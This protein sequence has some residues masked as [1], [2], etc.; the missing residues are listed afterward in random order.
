MILSEIKSIYFLGIGGIGMS[1]LAR[2][3]HASGVEVGG[4]DKTKTSL[5]DELEKEG[6]NIHFEDNVVHAPKSVSL[7]VY[8]PAIPR[9]NNIFRYYVEN[10]YQL[11]KR[12]ELLGMIT[13]EHFTIAV[14]GTHGKTS[15][16]A[17]IAHILKHAGKNCTAFVGGIMQ[18]YNSNLL[19]TKNDSDDKIIVVE[20]DEYDRSFLTLNPNISIITSMDAD[21]LDIYGEKEHLQESFRLFAKADL[22]PITYLKEKTLVTLSL[23][24]PMLLLKT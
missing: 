4:Y 22:K 1:A 5:T 13:A 20:A 23:M 24:V 11:K 10:G 6:I 8:T 19:V 3:F 2:Y 21:H 7:V 17:M 18:N 16:T 9:N 15:T 14:A 12:S